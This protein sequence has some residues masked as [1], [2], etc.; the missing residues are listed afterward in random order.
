[1]AALPNANVAMISVPGEYA[2]D[3]ADKAL[4]RGLHV[5]MFS[6]NVSVEEELRLK[7]KRM[8]KDCS[9]WVQTAEQEFLMVYR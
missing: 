8:I 9:L 1:M 2:A 3:E 6:D 7:Q 4:D 5:F